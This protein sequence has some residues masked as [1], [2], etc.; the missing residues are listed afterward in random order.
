[1]TG[2]YLRTPERWYPG[3]I[4]KI[5]L[6]SNEA[7]TDAGVQSIEV[8]CKVVRHGPDGVGLQFISYEPAERKGLHRFLAGVI[9]NVRR[10]KPARAETSARG[11]SL[12]EFALMI[13]LLFILIVLIVDFGGFLYAW[14][15]VAN[16]ARSGV[17]YAVLGGASV[18]L[19][20]TA[21]G[22]QVNT[23]VT[24][25]I[26]SLLGGTSPTVNVCKSVNGTITTLYGT[27]SSAP[28]DPEATRYV[29]D[30][31]D[32]TYTYSPFI[33]TFNFSKLGFNVISLMSSNVT[34]HRRAVMRDLR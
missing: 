23:L 20:S 30:W 17:E 29:V 1:L 8:R 22:A 28:S 10:A 31:V 12:V 15:T 24:N 16:A 4:V 3:T 7:G 19:P 14:I 18:G 21:T 34:I 26:Y 9:A 13:P 11:Q 27:C 6:K 5:V 2:A 25:D 33:R 32:V